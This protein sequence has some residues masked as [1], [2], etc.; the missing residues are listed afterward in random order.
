MRLIIP[1]LTLIVCFTSYGQE[2]TISFS[3]AIK[4]NIKKY[5][6][7]TD[8]AFD[9]GNIERGNALFDSLVKNHLVG[10]RFDDYSFK[11][12]NSRKVKL[13]KIKKPVFIITYASWCVMNKGEI[14]ALN[15]LARKYDDEIQFIVVFWDMKS[16]VT[17]ISRQFNSKIKVC[18]ANE[19]YKNDA[20]VVATLKHTLGFPTSY[21]LNSDLEV[22]DI[23]RGGIAIP[24]KTAF[25]K[26]MEM[27]YDIFNERLI[28]FFSKKELVKQQLAN[29]D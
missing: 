17:K 4:S 27:N 20:A 3:D 14:P 9:K 13:G 16:D 24:K 25:K 7:Q 29:N 23:K 5:N 10:S 6:S 11:C 18:Y 2:K 21:F 12:I 15:K 8:A 19:S 26:A 22:V 28:S 1:L